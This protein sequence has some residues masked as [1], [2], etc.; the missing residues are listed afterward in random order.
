MIKGTKPAIVKKIQPVSIHGQISLDY[1]VDPERPGRSGESGSTGAGIGAARPRSRRSGRCSLYARRRDPD[2]EAA[3]NLKGR[4]LRSGPGLPH[5]GRH[6]QVRTEANRSTFTWIRVASGRPALLRLIASTT[7]AAALLVPVAL[8]AQA[9]QAPASPAPKAAAP[10]QTTSPALPSAR[11]IVDRHIQAIGGAR[12][13][14]PFFD[15][16]NGHLQRDCPR[17]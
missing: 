9:A 3:G 8:R 11:S 16:R 7:L 6:S 15:T 13:A 5:T 10:A 14:Q 17:E 12:R 2:Y 4:R 1:F